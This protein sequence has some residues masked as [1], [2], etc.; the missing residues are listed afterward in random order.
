MGRQIAL[1]IIGL[2]F[3]AGIGFLVALESGAKLDGHAHNPVGA[4]LRN[5][6]AT[7]GQQVT[8]DHGEMLSLTLDSGAPTLEITLTPDTVS[9]WNLHVMTTNFRFTP[10]NV[11]KPHVPGEGHAHVFVNGNKIGRLYN[12]WMHIGSLPHGPAVVEVTLNTNDHRALAVGETP[13]MASVATDVN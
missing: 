7:A 11:G 8:H 12:S 3:G 10:G 6:K 9:G 13:L 5:A 4:D 2:T 1:L